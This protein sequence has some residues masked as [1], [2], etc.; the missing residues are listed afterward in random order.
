VFVADG[1]RTAKEAFGDSSRSVDSFRLGMG[2]ERLV[3]YGYAFTAADGSFTCEHLP[4]GPYLVAAEVESTAPPPMNRMPGVVRGVVEG[5][6]TGATGIVVTIPSESP[7]PT[8]ALEVVVTDD[9]GRPVESCYVQASVGGA[10][11]GA[12]M[13]EPTRFRVDALPLGTAE[14]SVHSQGWLRVT[15]PDVEIR[16]DR[17]PAPV[18]VRLTRGIS[19]RG[20][21]RAQTGAL[22]DGAKVVVVP[23]ENAVSGV[24]AVAVIAKDGTFEAT[25]LVAGRYRATVSD[26]SADGRAGAV[27]VPVGDATVRVADDGP[28][29]DLTVVRAGEIALSVRDPRLPPMPFGGVKPD[30][31]KARFGA[32]ARIEVLDAAGAT[33]FVQTPVY[34]DFVPPARVAPGTCTVRLTFPGEA[35]RIETCTVKEGESVAVRFRSP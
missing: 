13:R 33:V 26:V 6:A 27:F 4:D 23:F 29:V 14:V 30:P 34:G 10:N 35:P 1:R 3:D 12:T 25:G 9:A 17:P 5:V 22:P 31:A 18:V 2:D 28:P 16:A 7:A 8:Q 20:T 32:D 24:S 21:V 11:Y 15:V 19:L